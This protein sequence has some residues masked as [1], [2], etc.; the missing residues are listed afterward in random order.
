MPEQEER[1]RCRYCGSNNFAGTATCWQ[2]NRPLNIS[3][4]A[5][6]PQP[7]Q[8]P[9]NAVQ[10]WPG[11]PSVASFA[12]TVD[13]LTADKAVIA[14]GLIF[15][16]V[17]YPLGIAFMMLDDLRKMQLGKS[18]LIWSTIGTVIAIVGSL[19]FMGAIG[20]IAGKMLPDSGGLQKMMPSADGN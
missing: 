7:A 20:G 5:A 13:P 16:F 2:C 14:M 11:N 10:S 6:E 18:L 1:I 4:T 3:Q 8:Q 9:I 15:P 19:M 12:S 17:G